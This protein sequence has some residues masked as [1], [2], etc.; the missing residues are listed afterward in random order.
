MRLR[1]GYPEIVLCTLTWGTIGPIVRHIDMGGVRIA[2]FREAFGALAVLGTLA[3]R[4]RLSDLRP[5]ARPVLLIASGVILGVH[6]A[7]LFIGYQRIGVAATILI[8]FLG[9]VLM[10][11]AAPAVL[12]ERLHRSAIVALAL[13]FG[14]VALIAVPQFRHADTFGL[15]AAMTSAVLFAA[16]MLAG[17]LLT[18]EYEPAAIAAWQL[19]VAA[20]V[21]SPSLAG[22]STH[23]IARG[24]PL[25]ALLGLVHT[26]ALGIVFFHAV[27]ALEAQRLGVLFYLEPA[28][29]V[30]FAWLIAGEHPT[31]ATL[32]GGALIVAAGLAIIVLDRVATAPAGMPD[33]GLATERNR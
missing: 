28:A 19:V 1:R 31:A 16:L 5:R 27:R 30:F 29:A 25:L 14:G 4:R 17:K 21:L 15:V 9:P 22:A 26:G 10:A 32:A 33:V 24:L 11:A 7:L 3:W 23:S 8:V 2:F 6:W 20:L 13:A 12:R 18:R